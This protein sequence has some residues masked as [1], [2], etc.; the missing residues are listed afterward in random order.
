MTKQQSVEFL[1]FLHKIED[2]ESK[3]GLFT[4]DAVMTIIEIRAMYLSIN[5][6]YKT[7]NAKGVSGEKYSRN[8]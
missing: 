3:N 4:T 2:R 6:Q 1:K 5:Q 8:K 7:K